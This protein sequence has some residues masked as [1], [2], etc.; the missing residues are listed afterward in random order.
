MF[1]EGTSIFRLGGLRDQVPKS[2]THAAG[3]KVK[4]GLTHW[5]ILGLYWGYIG[6]LLGLYL[7]NGKENGNY[8]LGFRVKALE[9]RGQS[10]V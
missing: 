10:G 7:D 9:F 8:D 4:K 5:V 2:W 6:D 3:R 1:L